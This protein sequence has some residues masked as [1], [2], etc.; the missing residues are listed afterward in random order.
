MVYTSP[1]KKA[2][3]VHLKATGLS[4]EQ[5]G[6]IFNIHRS[7]VYRIHH[8]HA[9]INDFYYVKPK[10]GRPRKFTTHDTRIAARMLASTEAHD[11]ADLQRLRF[12]HVTAETIRRRLAD[13]GLKS[14]IC[15]KKPFLSPEKKKKRLAWAEAHK[16]WT[17]D[18]WKA[19]IFS[20]ESKFNL[21]G[22]D[23]RRYC[24]R[25]PGQQFDERYVRKEIK[26]GGGNVM[27]WGCITAK[28]LGRICRIE[29]N[30]DAKLYVEILNDDV[31][32]TL[33][34]LEINKK[35]IY[36]QQD[37]DPKHTS[38]LAQ[39]WFLQKKLDKLDW[40]ASSLDMNII[41]HL[42]E[43]LERRVRT[44]NALPRNHGDMWA[45]LQEEWGGIEEEYIDK[46][47]QSMPERIA[48]LIAAKGGHT[49]Y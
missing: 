9:K 42:W 23:G 18:D 26:H 24:W 31:L 21:F 30:M 34:D 43:Y 19:V 11:V 39:D 29:G 4:D 22:S 8:R 35:D 7:T 47:Y 14:Y 1:T 36:F 6:A 49:R 3:I 32:G 38:R 33:R 12:P 5:I 48:A 25:K 44:R 40:P 41:E 15:R 37:N 16:H 17:V 20:N 2:R 27:V 10:P 46:L 13:C 28:G 45:A